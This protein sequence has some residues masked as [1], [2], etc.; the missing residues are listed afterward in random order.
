M[1]KTFIILVGLVLGL[2]LFRG[3]EPFVTLT[4]LADGR[5]YKVMA[6]PKAKLEQQQVRFAKGD[7]ITVVG[8]PDGALFLARMIIRADMV[9][10]V[11]EQ[12]GSPIGRVRE[13][14]AQ[15]R[16]AL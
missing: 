9:L 13:G 16:V 14:L 6:G 15:P 1:K 12:D 3:P 11:L 8:M 4:F 2:T 10:T 7:A 5:A